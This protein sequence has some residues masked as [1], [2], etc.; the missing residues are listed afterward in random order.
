VKISVCQYSFHRTWAA[1]AWDAYRFAEEA[2]KAGAVAIDFHVRMVGSSAKAAD[3]ILAALDRTGLG[4]SGL[5]LSNNFGHEDPKFVTKEIEETISWMRIAKEVGAPA[6]RIFGSPVPSG[7]AVYAR[8]DN[9]SEELRKK[10]KDRVAA[11]LEVITREAERLELV[12]ALENHHEFPATGEEQVEMI[13]RVNSKFLRATVDVGNYMIADQAP[14]AGTARAAPYAA[15]VHVKDFVRVPDASVA[16]GWKVVPCAVGKGEVDHAACIG[17]LKYAGFE[18]YVAVEY[19]GLDDER[20]GVAQSV[21]FL[22]Q[23]CESSQ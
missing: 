22:K 15:Y 7:Y 6:S 19:E 2:K 18:G 8:P 5:S 12:L 13:E 17:I 11:A 16:S 14:E 23:L 4:L 10:L 20:V 9:C 3:T 1:E 21:Q